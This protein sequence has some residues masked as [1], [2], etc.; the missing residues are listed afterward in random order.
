VRVGYKAGVCV[1]YEVGSGVGVAGV[2][3]D[4]ESWGRSGIGVEGG[5]AVSIAVGVTE[6]VDLSDEF[7][8]IPSNSPP[9]INK[10]ATVTVAT[11]QATL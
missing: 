7:K 6:A 2:G 4:R 5:N 10:A 9:I 11:T 1:G 3:V 8:F